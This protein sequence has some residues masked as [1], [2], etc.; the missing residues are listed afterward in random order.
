MDAFSDPSSTVANFQRLE[1]ARLQLFLGVRFY[2]FHIYIYILQLSDRFDITDILLVR[3]F[4]ISIRCF[5]QENM[6][7]NSARLT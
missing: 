1:Q 7:L 3:K 5:K 4:G 6:V 2:L